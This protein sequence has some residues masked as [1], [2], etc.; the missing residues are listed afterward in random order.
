MNPE[1]IVPVVLFVCI[2]LTFIVAIR[3]SYRLKMR[4]LDLENGDKDGN[5]ADMRDELDQLSLENA[6]MKRE[7]ARIKRTL[8]SSETRI[9]LTPYEREQLKMDQ[10]NKFTF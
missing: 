3:S 7:I 8:E 10:D 2:F 4:K 5:L 9:D 1:I 6:A